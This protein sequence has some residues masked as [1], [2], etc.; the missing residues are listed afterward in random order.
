MPTERLAMRKVKEVLRLRWECGLSYRQIARSCAAGRATVTDYVQRATAAGLSWEQ[1][2]GLDDTALERQLF[3][4]KERSLPSAQ[5]QPDW[6]LVHQEL[7]RKGV[8]LYLLWEEY[9]AAQPDGYQYSWFCKHYRRWV[10]KL[11]VVLRQEHRTVRLWGGGARRF[12]PTVRKG[13]PDTCA[14]AAETQPVR[15]WQ[16]Q[17]PRGR[18]AGPVR[19]ASGPSW[20]SS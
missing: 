14:G 15:G 5:P 6:A 20:P 7:K 2:V 17:L 16:G 10:G 4:R 1:V 8:T 19:T 12:H 9:K 3:V 13:E 11:D 18:R